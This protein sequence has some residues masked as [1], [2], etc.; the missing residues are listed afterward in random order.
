MKYLLLNVDLHYTTWEV[1]VLHLQEKTGRK[2]KK[3]S[4]KLTNVSSMENL[5]GETYV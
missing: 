3:T 2:G 5:Y 4:N 1:S